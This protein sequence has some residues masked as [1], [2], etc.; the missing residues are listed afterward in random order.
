MF[1]D[2]NQDEKAQFAKHHG[3]TVQQV[4]D[5]IAHM[6]RMNDI[7]KADADITYKSEKQRRVEAWQ[8]AHPVLQSGTA[9]RAFVNL[10]AF[11]RYRGQIVAGERLGL[12]VHRSGAAFSIGERI[13]CVLHPPMQGN[14]IKGY[15]VVSYPIGKA[16]RKGDTVRTYL[17]MREV[18]GKKATCCGCSLQINKSA[19]ASKMPTTKRCATCSVKVYKMRVIVRRY[20]YFNLPQ[21]TDKIWVSLS[22]KQSN[23]LRIFWMIRTN[24]V[25]QMQRLRGNCWCPLRALQRIWQKHARALPC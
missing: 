4:E 22:P 8:R 2:M 14:Y 5:Y 25:S 7:A 11:D 6:L 21:Q 18:I 1:L 3:M 16:L 17:D 23:A 20:V 9:V 10:P 15:R 24:A 12:C 13:C 19:S